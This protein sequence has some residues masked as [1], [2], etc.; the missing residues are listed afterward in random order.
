MQAGIM[1]AISENL[2][3][4]KR[5]CRGDYRRVNNEPFIYEKYL[6]VH[7]FQSNAKIVFQNYHGPF[8][9]NDLSQGQI[10]L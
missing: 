10:I 4:P 2:E 9:G 8:I 1:Q 6:E 3:I 7:H 5:I